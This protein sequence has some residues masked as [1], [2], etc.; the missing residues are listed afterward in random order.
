M[1]ARTL[2]L[3]PLRAIEEGSRV[4]GIAIDSGEAAKMVRYIQ[5][6]M[7][8]SV[9]TNLTSLKD[10]VEIA[11]FHFLDSLTVFKVAPRFAGFRVLDVGS[12]AGFPGMVMK[13]ADGSLDMTL[14]DPNPRKIVFLKEVARK[15]GLTGVS[16]LNKKLET[17][18]ES[19]ETR[20]F[21]LVVSRA[22]SSAPAFFERLNEVLTA[23]GLL[24]RMGGPSSVDEGLSSVHFRQ[25]VVWEGTLPFSDRFRRVFLYNKIA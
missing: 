2:I 8:W 10:P 14:L 25:S 1:N 24:V 4:L 11:V 20:N 18:L 16:F 13:I 19:L 3:D 6:L 12:G 17:L 5:L 15:L 7:E 23:N 9:R 22:L 21:D